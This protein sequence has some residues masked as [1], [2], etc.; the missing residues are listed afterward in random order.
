MSYLSEVHLRRPKNRLFPVGQESEKCRHVSTSIFRGPND[1]LDRPS[2]KSE[3]SLVFKC[4]RS[5]SCWT[6]C[7]TDLSTEPPV[8]S[9][10]AFARSFGGY[11]AS[12]RTTRVYAVGL[13]TAAHFHTDGRECELQARRCP[14]RGNLRPGS[15]RGM[16]AL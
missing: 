1:G 10:F 15:I 3:V 9:D 5:Q 11:R 12:R 13:L 8:A 4:S 6:K 2:E 14:T 16:E 7:C